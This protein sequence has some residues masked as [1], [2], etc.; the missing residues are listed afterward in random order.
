MLQ[1]GEY[2][3]LARY[4]F[5]GYRFLEFHLDSFLLTDYQYATSGER[6]LAGKKQFAK[7]KSTPA[8]VFGIG[9]SRR[10]GLAEELHV[11]PYGKKNE[12]DSEKG[13]DMPRKKV[14]DL[15][16]LVQAVQ[17]GIHSK[18]IMADFE[19]KTKAQ[20]KALYVDGLMAA[21]QIP[22]L[23]SGRGGGAEAGVE[24][25]AKKAIRVNKRGSLVVPRELIDVLGFSVGDIFSVR[26]SAAG[27]SL[28]KV[29]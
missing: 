29:K 16:K 8:A 18:Q 10:A 19:L 3:S 7:A 26:K 5:F 9:R 20:L 25:G 1:P 12:N 17:S 6:S 11:L 2:P 14:V 28:K 23:E 22:P 15:Q 24:T 4:F 21:G 13:E 27:V